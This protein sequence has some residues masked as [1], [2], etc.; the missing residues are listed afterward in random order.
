MKKGF[1][2]LFAV[3][4]LAT[5]IVW[6]L[7]ALYGAKLPM[8]GRLDAMVGCPF[9]NFLGGIFAGLFG[10][11]FMSIFHVMMFL[12]TATVVLLAFKS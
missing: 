3:A 1:E 5:I 4:I 6:F 12:V 7:V 11:G 9:Y 8:M 2:S 10:C